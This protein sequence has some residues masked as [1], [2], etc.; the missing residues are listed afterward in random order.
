MD[1]VKMEV[2][3]DVLNIAINLKAQGKPSSS[4][5][6]QVIATTSGNAAVPGAEGVKIGLNCYRPN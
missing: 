1:N 6:S 2:K 4:G 3:G 5:K